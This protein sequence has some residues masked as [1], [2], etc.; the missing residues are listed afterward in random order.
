MIKPIKVKV[1][2]MKKEKEIFNRI[3]DNIAA[4]GDNPTNHKR[5]KL[6]IK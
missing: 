3:I 2:N 6:V 5:L 4:M 1:D